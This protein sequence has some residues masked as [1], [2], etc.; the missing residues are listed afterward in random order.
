[1]TTTEIDELED[2]RA[3]IAL[4]ARSDPDLRVIQQQTRAA[5]AVA[6]SLAALVDNAELG[7]EKLARAAGVSPTNLEAALNA[8]PGSDIPIETIRRIAQALHRQFEILLYPS[9]ESVPNDV[10]LSTKDEAVRS[11]VRIRF[12]RLAASPKRAEP[13]RKLLESGVRDLTF[14]AR[15]RMRDLPEEAADLWEQRLDAQIRAWPEASTPLSFLVGLADEAGYTIRLGFLDVAARE[16]R[17]PQTAKPV[18]FGSIFGSS[19][20][21]SEYAFESE[22]RFMRI[23]D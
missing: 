21:R 3:E 2:L 23:P 8:T 10:G 4:A 7:L 19:N 14:R 13:T 11:W 20:T 17:V 15:H 18:R 16:D 5:F 22:F 1:M 9:D 12:P 6:E